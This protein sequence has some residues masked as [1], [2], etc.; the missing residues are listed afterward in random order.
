V[1]ADQRKLA[2]V[3]F[4][5]NR[6]VSTEVRPLSVFSYGRTKSDRP[7]MSEKCPNAE[8]MTIRII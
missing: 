8:V 7:G 4:G 1:L 5:S 2:D 6:V 3:R